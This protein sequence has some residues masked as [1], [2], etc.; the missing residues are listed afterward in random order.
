MGLASIDAPLLSRQ[1]APSLK[2][3]RSKLVELEPRARI[4]GKTLVERVCSLYF[5]NCVR[6]W[7][8]AMHLER[9]KSSIKKK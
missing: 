7:A 5:S 8:G 9:V 4:D 1:K 3:M 2:F 6:N